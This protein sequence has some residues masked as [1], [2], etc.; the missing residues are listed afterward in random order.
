MMAIDKGGAGHYRK[1]SCVLCDEEQGG[2]G[3]AHTCVALRSHDPILID[4][5]GPPGNLANMVGS[6]QRRTT[7]YKYIQLWN[8]PTRSLLSF[9]SRKGNCD[10]KRFYNRL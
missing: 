10:D 1:V 5:Q 6:P 4:A 7:L 3:R 9:V 2:G 8:Q